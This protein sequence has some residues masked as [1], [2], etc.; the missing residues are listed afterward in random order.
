MQWCGLNTSTPWER[1]LYRLQWVQLWRL[2]QLLAVTWIQPHDFTVVWV[3]RALPPG[4]RI[5]LL[6]SSYSSL[7]WNLCII[8]VWQVIIYSNKSIITPYYNFQFKGLGKKE[9]NLALT[10]YS[11]CGYNQYK[12]IFWNYPSFYFIFF[13]LVSSLLIIK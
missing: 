1:R 4:I 5:S 2:T 11:K 12:W 6:I 8:T 10:S 7:I 13:F 9:V 3:I